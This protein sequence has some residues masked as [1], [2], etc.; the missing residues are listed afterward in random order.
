[1]SR[2]LKI[3]FI[4]S[5]FL[6]IVGGAEI[7][8][9]NLAN[10]ISR[11]GHKIDIWNTKKGFYKKKLYKIKNFNKIIL[12]STYILR[13]YFKIKFNFFLKSYIAKIID[14][15]NYDIW[16]FHSVNFKTLIIFEIL[17][18]LNQ[19]VVFTFH[20]ADIQLNKK[21]GY[22]YRLDLN[23]DKMLKKNLKFVDRVHS[24]SKEIENDLIKLN[25]PQKKILRI[26]DCVDLNKFKKYKTQKTKRLTLITV[27]R[28]AEKKK[29]FDF[30]EKIGK[31]LINKINFKWIIIGRNV[32][33]LNNNKFI[34][35]HRDNF[36]LVEEIKN[37]EF[38]FP[39]SKLIKYY[40]SSTIY[41]HLSR[42][43]SFGITILEALSSELP[44]ISFMSTGSKTLIKNGV[45]GYLV[46]CFDTKEYAKTIFKIYKSKNK[47]I[48][49]KLKDLKKYDLIFNTNK[50]INDYKYLIKN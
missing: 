10:S 27:A 28:Y 30:V 43:E 48:K 40:K 44:I 41:L 38:F 42:I 26:P 6:P 11:R 8:T 22:G 50:S 5:T 46:K 37:N 4:P 35:K 14:S 17:K 18:E 39:N 32:T 36:K 9:H 34:S 12:N 20:G 1:V 16:H 24:I 2:N 13:Y 49:S 19:K 45:N 15:K 31:Q 47:L 29:G 7:Q 23:Y 21:I 3:A 33:N 25:F